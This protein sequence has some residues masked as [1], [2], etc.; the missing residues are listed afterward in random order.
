MANVQQTLLDV[1]L[2]DLRLAQVRLQDEYCINAF[3][4]ELAYLRR[5]EPDRLLSSFRTNRGFHPR[6]SLIL[7]GKAQRFAAIR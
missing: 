1:P 7:A 3:D 5:Y 4:K 6:L 2:K